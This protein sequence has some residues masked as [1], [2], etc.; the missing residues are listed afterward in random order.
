MALNM[1][2]ITYPIKLLYNVNNMR[3]HTDSH[4]LT[5]ALRRSCRLVFSY[6]NLIRNI[7]LNQILYSDKVYIM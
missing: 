1:I 4:I 3:M 7:S 2:K 6:P 5:A